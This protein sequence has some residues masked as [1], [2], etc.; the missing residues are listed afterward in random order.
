M[1]KIYI[2]IIG[3]FM[4]HKKKKFTKNQFFKRSLYNERKQGTN[5]G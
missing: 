3:Y 5:F 2:N 4:I 1:E